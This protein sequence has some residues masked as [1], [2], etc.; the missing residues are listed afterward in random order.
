MGSF[1]VGSSRKWLLARGINNIN[2]RVQNS[3]QM[4]K[5]TGKHTWVN[6]ENFI[7]L[8]ILIPRSQL[9][10]IFICIWS[11]PILIL[12]FE[13]CNS[14]GYYGRRGAIFLSYRWFWSKLCC[15]AKTNVI[16]QSSF[17][18][19]IVARLIQFVTSIHKHLWMTITRF[20]H[21]WQWSEIKMSR[22][23]WNVCL[24]WISRSYAGATQQNELCHLS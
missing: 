10:W 18:R 12:W 21:S 20:L 16:L 17:S 4:L 22:C 19:D 7:R 2:W 3:K 5:L 6:A 8:H 13:T 15:Y 11:A 24:M 14:K 1:A 9:D 23:N